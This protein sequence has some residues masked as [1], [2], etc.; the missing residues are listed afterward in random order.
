LPPIRPHGFI[1]DSDVDI[2]FY[3]LKDEDFFKAISFLSRRLARDVDVIQLEG[4]RLEEKRKSTGIK[5]N[6]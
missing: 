3:K 6:G 5:W 4:H 2:A 1:P